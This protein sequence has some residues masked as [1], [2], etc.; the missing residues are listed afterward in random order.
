MD[1]SISE[2]LSSKEMINFSGTDEHQDVIEN[3]HKK[4]FN[5]N[6]SVEDPL[7]KHRTG[8]NQTALVSKISNIIK[9]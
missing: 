2:D 5:W 8:S 6:S 4:Y 1:I 3:I 9:D 7:S